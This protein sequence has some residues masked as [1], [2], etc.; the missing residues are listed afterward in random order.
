MR[1][2]AVIAPPPLLAAALPH[3]P[4]AVSPDDGVG[5]ILVAAPDATT[6]HHLH[7]D[8][9]HDAALTAD[10][11]IAESVLEPLCAPLSARRNA[12][13]VIAGEADAAKDALFIAATQ[14]AVDTLLVAGAT[15]R[16]SAFTI[17][18]DGE[19]YIGDA[20]AA[21]AGESGGG[22][23]AGN[24]GS[25][26]VRR[27]GGSSSDG[28]SHSSSLSS[29]KGMRPS[30]LLLRDDPLLGV[31]VQG[32][33]E[34]LVNS[35]ED[36]GDMLAIAWPALPSSATMEPQPHGLYADVDGVGAFGTAP[37]HVVCC[38]T[39]DWPEV[40]RFASPLPLTSSA[41]GGR[42]SSNGGG[43]G[44]GGGRISANGQSLTSR[45]TLVRLAAASAPPSSRVPHSSLSDHHHSVPGA[46]TN[47]ASTPSTAAVLPSAAPSIPHWV[48][49]L[50]G[51]L[52]AVEGRAAT[53][54]FA[55]SRAT[56]LLR[57]LISGRE[58]GALV[59]VAPNAARAGPSTL[60]FGCR[61]R[62]AAAD[63]AAVAGKGG[64]EGARFGSGGGGGAYYDGGGG[65]ANSQPNAVAAVPS[66]MT[67]DSWSDS[68]AFDSRQRSVEEGYYYSP[69][70]R[71][72]IRGSSRGTPAT[73][74]PLSSR[75][76]DYAS[77]PQP[78]QLLHQRRPPP[79]P[80]PRASEAFYS[81]R[82]PLIYDHAS[83]LTSDADGDR[84][85]GGSSSIDVDV[86]EAAVDR[87]FYQRKGVGGG[88]G[89]LGHHKSGFMTQSIPPLPAYIRDPAADGTSELDDSSSSED[90]GAGAST[91]LRQLQ[92]LSLAAIESTRAE[93]YSLRHAADAARDAAVLVNSRTHHADAAVFVISGVRDDVNVDAGDNAS[94]AAPPPTVFTTTVG[95]PRPLRRAAVPHTPHAAPL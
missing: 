87:Y 11:E 22:G 92:A 94:T 55:D 43:G 14:A 20:L 95:L 27:G 64:G 9:A 13:I 53:I 67:G 46:A 80:P 49:A 89:D 35:A 58:E 5:T 42:S 66:T 30:P 83:A 62:A 31:C 85:G 12:R 63:L 23:D 69:E 16:L 29:R 36:V 52:A 56:L 21:A 24:G 33:W 19:E 10:T 38:L 57:D 78:A 90:A 48:R 50:A 76:L 3:R 41:L 25:S 26:P 37:L 1:V 45:V 34:V 47:T 2:H 60:Q 71:T 6:S 18:C 82:G 8:G 7:F 86:D 51:V 72:E 77:R 88:G 75:R 65:R 54:P 15:V 79:P 32:G 40:A 74:L 70:R 17:A 59:V 61:L 4:L 68:S 44:S 39:A 84:R 81:A 91:S 28:E 73:L 93:L